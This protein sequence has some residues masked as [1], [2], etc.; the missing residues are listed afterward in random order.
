MLLK[1]NN[2]SKSFDGLKALNNLSL[3]VKE[4]SLTALIGPNGCGKSTLFNIISAVLP[5][6]EISDSIIFDGIDILGKKTYQD[7]RLFKDLTVLENLMLPPKKQIGERILN[8][9]F[10]SNFKKQ[11]EELK[12]K[13]LEILELLDIT[14]MAY[15]YAK[16]LSGGQ[17]KLVD[18]GRV[19]MS[20]PKMLLLDEPTAGVNPALTEKLFQKIVELKNN[21]GLTI[22]LIEHDMDVIMRA[23]VDHVYVANQGEIITHGSPEEV[24]Q[25]KEVIEAYLGK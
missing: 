16:N 25:N 2:I 20:S 8:A 22:L 17:S 13:A 4:N 1:I 7:T 5:A 10:R 12:S 14:H 6:D 18:I 9:L 3:E 23:E 21:L 15:E 19:L 11:E 24:K